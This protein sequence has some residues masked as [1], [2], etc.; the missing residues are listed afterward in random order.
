MVVA[1]EKDFQA[2]LLFAS[3]SPVFRF[4]TARMKG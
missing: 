2:I 3:D 4:R 1:A